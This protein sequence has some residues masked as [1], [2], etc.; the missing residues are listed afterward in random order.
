[1]RKQR[2]L[3]RAN[4]KRRD[5]LVLI[6]RSGPRWIRHAV[7]GRSSARSRSPPRGQPRVG[8]SSVASPSAICWPCGTPLRRPT[9]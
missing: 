9:S 1:V 6:A 7:R 8:I 5:R 3:R 2:S 4:A